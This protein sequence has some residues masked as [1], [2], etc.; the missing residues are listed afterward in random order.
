MCS[1]L[2]QLYGE[3]RSV[4]QCNL[5]L[6][7][8]QFLESKTQS[9]LRLNRD[10]HN[11]FSSSAPRSG[12]SLSPLLSFP[13][14]FAESQGLVETTLDPTCPLPR[15]RYTWVVVLVLPSK[16]DPAEATPSV[17]LTLASSASST[18]SG[19]H[20]VHSCVLSGPL[21]IRSPK[22]LLNPSGQSV[23]KGRSHSDSSSCPKAPVGLRIAEFSL[24]FLF[25]YFIAL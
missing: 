2:S 6:E 17:L 7:K 21:L 23:C 22:V 11:N 13:W 24:R 25:C 3:C 1:V 5:K 12:L 10:L 14:G 20:Q 8:K 4:I 16:E 19:R 9:I 18:V 15:L